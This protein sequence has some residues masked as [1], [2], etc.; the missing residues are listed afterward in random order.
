V[1][2]GVEPFGRD[3][4]VGHGGL[5]FEGIRNLDKEERTRIPSVELVVLVVVG[6]EVERF[7]HPGP[8][9]LEFEGIENYKLKAR[10]QIEPVVVKEVDAAHWEYFA[11]IL[12]ESG[13]EP[14]GLE[15]MKDFDWEARVQIEPVV[16]EE[17]D[18]VYWGYFAF[19]VAESGVEERKQPGL[20]VLDE[21]EDK[22]DFDLGERMQIGSVVVEV[23]VA[24]GSD[25]VALP[26]AVAE[27]AVNL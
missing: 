17:V 10:V 18:V 8:V 21:F 13:G 20:A 6:A 15:G 19:V 9:G 22:L 1:D 23:I 2:S 3:G 5:E 25:I 14:D 7:G 16:V 24:V 27:V 4:H 26:V 11:G 12:V